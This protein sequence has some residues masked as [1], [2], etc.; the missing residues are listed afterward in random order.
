[1][2]TWG[3]VGHF[4]SMIRPAVLSMLTQR[5]RTPLIDQLHGA[6]HIEEMTHRWVS[7]VLQMIDSGGDVTFSRAKEI[8]CPVLLMLGDR[9]DLNPAELGRSMAAAL[10]KGRLSLYRR[11]GHAIHSE[12]PHSFRREVSRFLNRTRG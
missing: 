12:R 4:D 8:L 6:E 1:V 7:A 11:T 2:L 3:A 5:W 9:D 10:P